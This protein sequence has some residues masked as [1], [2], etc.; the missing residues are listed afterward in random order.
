MR[1]GVEKVVLDRPYF[2]M[3]SV[4]IFVYKEHF[5]QNVYKKEKEKKKKKRRWFSGLSPIELAPCEQGTTCMT[6]LRQTPTQALLRPR[7]SPQ[8]E[9]L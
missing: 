2:Y 1:I 9:G 3:S 4:Y 8:V 6:M 5:T 7:T